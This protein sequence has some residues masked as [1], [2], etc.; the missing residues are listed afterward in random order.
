MFVANMTVFDFGATMQPCMQQICWK[1]KRLWYR[2]LELKLHVHQQEFS[3]KVFQGDSFSGSVDK[4][5]SQNWPGRQQVAGLW[6]NVGYLFRAKIFRNAY[7][8]VD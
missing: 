2:R 4:K 5:K 8:Q 7:F 1:Y 6:K 3:W